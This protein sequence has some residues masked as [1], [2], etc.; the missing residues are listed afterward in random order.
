MIQF[1]EKMIA[2]IVANYEAAVPF[3][4]ECKEEV[5]EKVN[6]LPKT[7]QLLMKYLYATMPLSDVGAYSFEVLSSY[8]K[9]G[10]F[11]LENSPFVAS[12]APCSRSSFK[13]P[14]VNETPP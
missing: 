7:E 13:T 12:V 6:S 11:L 9:H 8:A 4:G 2:K 14:F 3:F 10:A 1:S 5:V